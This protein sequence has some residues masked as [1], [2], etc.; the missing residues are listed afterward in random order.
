MYKPSFGNACALPVVIH[1]VK[2]QLK[3]MAVA[4]AANVGRRFISATIATCLRDIKDDYR[5][6]IHVF[7]QINCHHFDQ[8]SAFL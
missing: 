8:I 1:C 3:K 7:I 5:L 4:G 2:P 6:E